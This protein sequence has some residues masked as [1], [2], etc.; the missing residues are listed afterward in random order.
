VRTGCG[1]NITSN[2]PEFEIKGFTAK[3]GIPPRAGTTRLGPIST[4]WTGQETMPYGRRILV[5]EFMELLPGGSCPGTWNHSTIKFMTKY[6][7]AL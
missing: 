6:C 7:Y 1:L 5:F 4:P 3:H 2:S